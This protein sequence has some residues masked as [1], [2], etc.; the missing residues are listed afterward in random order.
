MSTRPPL[1]CSVPNMVQRYLG[2]EY[3]KVKSVADNIETVIEVKDNLDHIKVVENDLVSINTVSSNINEVIATNSNIEDVKSVATNIDHINTVKSNL[4]NVVTVA[5][6][7]TDVVTVSDNIDYVKDVAE[8]IEGLPVVSYIGDAP[9]TQ[10]LHGAEW[11]CTTDGRTYVWYEDVDS[12]QWVESSPQSV[13]ETDPS[14]AHTVVNNTENIFALWKRS[15]VEAGL[16]LVAGSFEEGG[17]LTSSTDVLLHRESK[18][19][20]G[21]AGSFAPDGKVV[22]AGSTP[23]TTGG[24]GAGAWVDRTQDTLRSDL[25]GGGSLG[26][27]Y[28]TI[29]V[30][31]P[32]FNGDLKAAYDAIPS[33]GN[34]VLMLG[35][36]SYNFIGKLR[37]ANKNTKPNIAFIGAGVPKYDPTTERLIDGS[38]TV[39]QGSIFNATS[40][41]VFNLGIDRGEWV[42]ANLAGGAYDDAF[43][44]HTFGGETTSEKIRYGDLIVLESRVV[45]SV[46]GSLTH[47]IL[48]EIGAGVIQTGTVEVIDGYHGHVV[49][50]QRFTGDTT[51]CR[52]QDG[53]GVII[54]ADA[55]AFCDRVHFKKIVIQGSSDRHSAGVY[56]EAQGGKVLS[57]VLIDELS[58]IDCRFLIK[59]AELTTNFITD[60]HIGK[61]VG[62]AIN[63]TGAQQ[64]VVIGGKVVNCTIGTHALNGCTNGGLKVSAGAVNVDIGSGFS[65]G[66]KAGDGYVFEASTQH[67]PLEAIDNS[68]YGVRNTSNPLLNPIIIHNFN[69]ASGGTLTPPT[70]PFTLSNSW[71]NSYGDF[72]VRRNGSLVTVNGQIND[73]NKGGAGW[74]YTEVAV[75]NE[76]RPDSTQYIAVNGITTTGESKPLIAKLLPSG[77]LQVYGLNGHNIISICFCGMYVTTN[78]QF[79]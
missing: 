14:I 17:V 61:V 66:A 32:P 4:E 36:R 35:R 57:Q 42:R 51:I 46:P 79:A 63:G 60:L 37:S 50:C 78:N 24:V 71:L 45:S 56:Y 21:W 1:G 59:Q 40:I 48:N 47:C 18:S 23:E 44:N 28:K 2:T 11:Y 15:A 8:G 62:S 33:T 27:E 26:S 5:D 9:P 13:I 39:I 3:D 73:G 74:S 34:T 49:K 7:I 16:N 52:Y 20:Y 19:I 53:T 43:V 41:A 22:T 77:S 25:S 12:G 68:G 31:L 54:K 55:N 65:K 29:I 70:V 69:N 64:A 38:G 10:P 6:N 72:K 75:L 58:G 30:D 76:C 67:G